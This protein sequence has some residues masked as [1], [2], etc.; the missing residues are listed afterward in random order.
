[1]M[2]SYVWKGRRLVE[3]AAACSYLLAL[4]S[5]GAIAGMLLIPARL[6]QAPSA[7][8]GYL[9]FDVWI[10]QKS[11]GLYRVKAWSGAAGFE[12]TEHFALPPAFGG[13]LCHAGGGAARGG[14][15]ADGGVDGATAE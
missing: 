15:V 3:F 2:I 8:P 11:E 10:D 5:A 6:A 12:A 9:D 14:L 13:Q 7:P 4:G 1:D